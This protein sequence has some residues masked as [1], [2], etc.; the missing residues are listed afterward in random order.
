[1][2]SLCKNPLKNILIY[3]SG[4]IE[5]SKTMRNSQKIKLEVEEQSLLD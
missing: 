2:P 4:C 5:M 3:H 1:M